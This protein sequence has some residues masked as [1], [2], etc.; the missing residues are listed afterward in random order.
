MKTKALFLSFL[1]L[2]TISIMA[3][4]PEMPMGIGASKADL[5][6]V[7]SS[8]H[9]SW[10]YTMEIN[11]DKGKSMNADYLLE[12][13]A[14]YFGMKMGQADMTMIMDTKK[15]ISV[16]AFGKGAQKM[17]TANKMPDYSA[18]ADKQNMSK[19]TYKTLA[20]KT[21]LGY[22]C[23]GVEATNPDYVMTF[24]YTNDA[25]VNFADMFKSPQAQKM[26]D[27]FKNFFKPGEK[28]LMMSVDIKD[29]KKGKT[30]SMNCVALE[31]NDFTFRKSDYK[32]M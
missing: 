15:K 6:E 22:K 5:S 7:P 27:A 24:Y 11:S 13:N 2:F 25:P 9:F 14:E 20:G 21:I 10:K 29:L 19:F 4:M 31:K 12:P 32:F 30:T 28:P 8:Y 26:P 18:M 23:K 16:T 17:A 1:S 3:Q